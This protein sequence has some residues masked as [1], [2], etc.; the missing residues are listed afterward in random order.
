MTDNSDFA[1]RPQHPDAASTPSTPEAPAASA[2]TQ[3]P[4]APQYGVQPP[5]QQSPFTRP[6]HEAPAYAATDAAVPNAAA[7]NAYGAPGYATGP[8]PTAAYPPS[9]DAQPTTEYART[10]A[11]AEPERKRGAKTVPLVVGAL[12]VGALAGG[13]SGAG[14]ASLTLNNAG[15]TETTSSS[16]TTVTVNKPADAT[17]ITAAAATA[18]PSTVTLFVTAEIGAGSGSGVVISEDGYIVTNSHV[19]TLGG[20]VA[21]PQ[22]QVQTYDGRL[23]DASVVGRDPIADIAVIKVDGAAGLQPAEWADSDELNVGDTTVVVGAPLG[24]AN[25]VSSGIVSAL[26][27]SITV[28]SS[29]VPEEVVPENGTEESPP[30]F[31]FWNFDIPGQEQEP[32]SASQRVSLA[33]IQTDAAINQGNSGGAL[34]NESGQVIGINVAIASTGGE[35]GG[36][37]GLG[38]AIPSKLAQRVAQELIEDGKASH[39]LLG[40]S[41]TDATGDTTVDADVVGAVIQQ[42]SDGGAAAAAGLRVGDVVTGVNGVPITSS[43]DLTAQIRALAGGSDA[44]IAYVR[45]GAAQLVKVTLGELD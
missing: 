11:P 44:E 38:F 34:V 21:D 2:T 8:Q 9:A 16:P 13:A 36:N 3:P 35:E 18:A 32:S 31:D 39:G 12:V 17:V 33:V 4:V 24:L 22:I 1:S 23:L 25:S 15:T 27:R 10:G 30:P 19:V 41:V 42:V 6:Q 29:E 28:S 7:P 26:N 20:A 40:A 43:T 5:A 37:I 14:I 45:G